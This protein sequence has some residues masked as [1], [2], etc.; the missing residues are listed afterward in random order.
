MNSKTVTLVT[1]SLLAALRATG[2]D[3]VW[4]NTAGGNWSV[5]A[6]WNLGRMP[7]ANDRVLITNQGTYTV[8]LDAAYGNYHDSLELGGASGT[9]TLTNASLSL[10]FRNASRIG[11][12]GRIVSSGGGLV[13]VGSVTVEGVLSL[14]GGNWAQATCIA[15]NGTLNITGSASKQMGS[16]T[17]DGTISWTGTGTLT[18]A[19]LH[20]RI[21][22]LLDLRDDARSAGVIINDGLLR[23]SAGA[24]TSSLWSSL[25]NTGVLEA[26]T[27]T[28]EYQAYAGYNVFSSGT[29]FTG[30][31]T[32]L[33]QVATFN[34]AIQVSNVVISGSILGDG[35]LSGTVDWQTDNLDSTASVTIA[36]N[37]L[38]VISGTAV[39]NASG[40]IT[41]TG[42]VI[43]SGTGSINLRDRG[44]IHNLA[45][46]TWDIRTNAT[47]TGASGSLFIND[48]L[49][50][51]SA[52]SGLNTWSVDFLNRG[53][54]A[55]DSGT[56]R[57]SG[58]Y[59]HSN[60]V[61]ALSGGTFQ[62]YSGQTLALNGG[63][64]T[65]YG[66]VSNSVSNAGII[67]PAAGGG[68]LRIVGDLMNTALGTVGFALGGTTAGV[69]HS[70]L[71]VTGR[72]ALGGSMDV[73]LV[74][75]FVPQTNDLFQVMS[76]GSRTDDFCCRNGCYLLG[77]DRRLVEDSTPTSLALTTMGAPDPSELNLSI[78]A[79]PPVLVCWPAEF[80]G[81]RLLSNTNVATT[82]WTEFSPAGTNRAFATSNGPA[83]FFRAVKP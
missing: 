63:S 62:Y 65:G 79:G 54:L 32:H 57:F 61:I 48:G 26:Q 20:N 75:G 39:R 60:A 70:R 41:N 72:A 2:A 40:S 24:G 13:G 59:A 17:N 10:L 28:I 1:L 83:R 58:D 12:N 6:N 74:G 56:V 51:K 47:L 9:Q 36:T 3:I 42:Q 16:V 80:G 35:I 4:T 15:T 23:K 77:Q 52:S 71:Q 19:R 43:C 78:S 11:P 27:G 82:D 55:I 5:G 14:G 44:W 30:A 34:G 64:L 73:N 81:W 69:N 18:F 38:L 68:V 25:T 49:C 29:V 53:T 31:G 22:A 66:N 37:G 8:T 21:G 7:G 76:F 50:R 67:A 46:A 33:C 45:G